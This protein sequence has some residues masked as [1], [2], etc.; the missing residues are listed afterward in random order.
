MVRNSALRMNSKV[1]IFDEPSTVLTDI[2]V[3]KLFTVIR[4]L[5]ENGMAIC[6]ISHRMDEISRLVIE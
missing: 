2:E 3:E 5:K 4:K 1:I 6:Y